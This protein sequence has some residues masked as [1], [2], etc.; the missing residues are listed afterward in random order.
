MS[1]NKFRAIKVDVSSF[2]AKHY[3]GNLYNFFQKAVICA[4][5]KHNALHTTPF[6]SV[7]LHDFF[8]NMKKITFGESKCN[9]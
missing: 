9:I 5:K 8:E 1:H 2:I 7:Q 4:S 3:K 6:N